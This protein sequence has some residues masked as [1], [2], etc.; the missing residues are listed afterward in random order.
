MDVV[1]GIILT[2]AVV[3]IFG[4][5]YARDRSR[6]LKL[7]LVGQLNTLSES[8]RASSQSLLTGTRDLILR[9]RLAKFGSLSALDEAL[10]KVGYLDAKLIEQLIGLSLQ[11]RDNDLELDRAI[12]L[13]AA[14]QVDIDLEGIALRIGKVSKPSAHL[15]QKL[16]ARKLPLWW[17]IGGSLTNTRSTTKRRKRSAET[18]TDATNADSAPHQEIEDPTLLRK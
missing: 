12:E 16:R 13:T 1:L 10:S 2:L 6:R 8:C 17:P 9:L 18:S 5:A 3:G 15:A 7:I 11:V 4:A 14:G